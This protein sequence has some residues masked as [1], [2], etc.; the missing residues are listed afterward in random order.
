M[1]N[2]TGFDQWAD[3]YDRSVARSDAAGSYPFAGY[4]EILDEIV[5]QVTEH[6]GGARAGHLA[7]APA[8]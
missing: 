3:E 1:L 5:R 7:S 2:N 6:G 8:R 4:Q